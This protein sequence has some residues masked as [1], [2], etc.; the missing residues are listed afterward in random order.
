MGL[1]LQLSKLLF[2]CLFIPPEVSNRTF[3]LLYCQYQHASVCVCVCAG[4]LLDSFLHGL[5]L[6]V[7]IAL[8]LLVECLH[9]WVFSPKGH[10]GHCSRQ[11]QPIPQDACQRGELRTA[12][13]HSNAR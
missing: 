11:T 9:H 1:L 8:H 13:H 6:S 4:H 7:Q 2:L 10:T 5:L 12:L 3:E